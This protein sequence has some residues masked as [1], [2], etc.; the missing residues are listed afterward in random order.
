ME[1]S[2]ASR[3]SAW[4]NS[5]EDIPA[6]TPK[7]VGAKKLSGWQNVVRESCQR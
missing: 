6:A 7:A 5:S 4:A 1:S 3:L 2:S